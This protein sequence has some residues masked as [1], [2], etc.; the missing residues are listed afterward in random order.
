VELILINE[1][2]KLLDRSP[3]MVRYYEQEGKL[4]A[5]RSSRGVRLFNR[6]DVEALAKE[7][8]AKNAEREQR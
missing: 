3:A 2:A 4:P 7:L 6:C 1:A 5:I 8:R